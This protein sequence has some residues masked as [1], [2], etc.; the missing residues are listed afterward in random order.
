MNAQSAYFEGKEVPLN[1]KIKVRASAKTTYKLMAKGNSGSDS[2][3]ITIDFYAATLNKLTLSPNSIKVANGS[4]VD[5]KLFFYDQKGT[6]I[7][8][9][10]YTVDWTITKGQGNFSSKGNSAA[11]FVPNGTDTINIVA[12]VG[13]ISSN[14]S[15]III[16]PS[17]KVSSI[18]GGNTE[19]AY[20]NPASD[21][22]NFK[23]N[24]TTPTTVSVKIYD[25][26]GAAKIQEIKLMGKGEQV[27]VLKTNKLTTGVYLYELNYGGKTFS[28]KLNVIK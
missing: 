26:K 2:L 28:G 6:Q 22:V 19:L 10:D 18:N 14:I 23:L 21:I 5:L 24:L 27:F 20:P 8:Y 12:K 15:T 17:T 7:K 11:V 4:N 25:L 1:G 16:K 9:P 3:F 13:N